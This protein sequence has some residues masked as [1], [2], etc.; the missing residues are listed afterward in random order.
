VCLN[1]IIASL[2]ACADVVLWGIDLKGG[3]ELQ[4]W[5]ACFEKLATTP[6]Q[7]DDLFRQAVARLDERAARMAAE[8]KRVWEPTPANPAL[9]IIA[10]E[11][12]KL[13]DRSH[14]RSDS[15][16][17]RGRAVAVN[18]IAATQRPTQNAMGKNTA[19][20]SQMDARICLRVRERRD[21]DLILGQGAFNSGWHAH[22]LAKPGEFLISDPEHAVAGRHRAYL[23]TDGQVTRHASRCEPAR[24]SLGPADPDSQPDAPQSPQAADEPTAGGRGIPRA[25]RGAVGGSQ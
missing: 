2:A 8:G 18:L 17:R 25:G 9:I 4:P 12:A 15:V 6:E 14:V 19:V 1:V 22:Q 10:D 23:I 16:A 24:P 7:A 21:A 20:R 5:A 13:P 11:Y 3:M